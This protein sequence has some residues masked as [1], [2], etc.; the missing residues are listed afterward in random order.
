MGVSKYT[1]NPRTAN[2][3]PP[4][5]SSPGA[6]PGMAPKTGSP[7]GSNTKPLKETWDGQGRQREHRHGTQGGGHRRADPNLAAQH[8]A[9]HDDDAPADA[10]RSVEQ[11][12]GETAA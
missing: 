12:R 3:L 1:E 10:E 5:P 11:A 2:P 9:R 8:Q 7:H 4:M 6:S